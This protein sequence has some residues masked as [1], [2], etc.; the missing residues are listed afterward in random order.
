MGTSNSK[1]LLDI[2]YNIL[3]LGD[4]LASLLVTWFWFLILT[5]AAVA[6]VNSYGKNQVDIQDLRSSIVSYWPFHE[7]LSFSLFDGM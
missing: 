3:W 4:N 6:I 7:S 2:L 1:D 5:A